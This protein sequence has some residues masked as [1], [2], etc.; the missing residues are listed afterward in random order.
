M[1]TRPLLPLRL[2]ALVV[3]VAPAPASA[4]DAFDDWRFLH[5]IPVA[6]KGLIEIEVPPEVLDAARMDLGDLRLADAEGKELPYIRVS[7]ASGQQIK[8]PDF[9][10][11]LKPDSTVLDIRAPG[12][13]PVVA[14]LL[15]S[16]AK[17][18]LK[19]VR[20]EASSDGASWL[21]LAQG[22]PIF[23]EAN[24]AEQ[25]RLP[26]APT[27]AGWLRLTID[28]SRSQPVPFSGAR[29]DLA[30]DSPIGTV[31]A[32]VEIIERVETPGQTRLE[33]DLGG[34]HLE[35]ASIGIES[36]DP[37]FVRKITLLAP[38]IE[39]TE[40]HERRLA[41]GT[42]FRVAIDGAVPRSQLQVP[43]EATAPARLLTLEVENGD[44]PPL[45]IT[46][47]SASRRAV[48]LRFLANS[49]GEFTLFAGNPNAG[50]PN[51]DVSS[52]ARGLLA[53]EASRY[54]VGPR[55]ENPAFSAAGQ[56]PQIPLSGAPLDTASWGYRK[57]VT[58]GGTGIQQLEL[59]SRV[60]SRTG[61]R[62]ADWRL[63]R[64]GT[65]VPFIIQ[66]S[67][68]ARSLTPEV[69]ESPDP[70]RPSLSRWEVHLPFE[71]LPATTLVCRTD[72]P[73]FDRRVTLIENVEDS[74]GQ[75]GS[76]TL[77]SAEWVRQP[78]ASDAELRINLSRRPQTKTWVLE[79]DNGDNAAITLRDFRVFYPALKLLFKSGDTDGLD[80]YYGNPKASPPVY[81]LDMAAAQLLRSTR[82]TATLG[83]EEALAAAKHGSRPI[84]GK[85]GLVF[86][87]VLTAVVGGLLLFIA[88][89]LP[90]PTTS[91]A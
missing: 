28:D 55:L 63:V 9:K 17:R 76:R 31:P 67:S 62:G 70:K 44:S 16:P 42:V 47:A 54:A 90:K 33:L 5:R 71:G 24:G 56:L 12:E 29:L 11:A 87:I 6:E 58:F 77:G 53:A 8:A 57:P 74:Y 27:E 81:D 83:E 73:L 18:F 66:R 14:V 34:A 13:R 7:A 37:L 79:L 15:S 86:W 72:A 52:I 91:D 10:A 68:F 2:I 69:S 48:R 75:K 88:K 80:L 22:V 61:I 65:Q 40:I 51:Y 4:A 30:S 59:D 84:G 36:E 1:K 25:L 32:L 64:D 23:R 41:G 45:E 35:L 20:I 78:E 46:G 38:A 3:L 39:D 43:I 49:A 60:L 82:S 21:P 19:A 50:S 26:F 85:S 89:L